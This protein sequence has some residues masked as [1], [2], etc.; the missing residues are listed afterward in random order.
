MTIDPQ[1]TPPTSHSAYGYVTACLIRRSTDD[2]DPDDLPTIRAAMNV[3][4]EFVP[5]R[6]Q[7]RTSDYPALLIEERVPFTVG[8]NGYIRDTMENSP[9]ALGVGDWT[10][11]FSG[12]PGVTLAPVEFSV[13]E[14]H[15]KAN[16]LNLYGLYPPTPPGG[17]NPVYLVVPPTVTVGHLLMLGASGIEG[18][19]PATLGGD[20]S[21]GPVVWDD[22]INKPTTFAPSAHRHDAS[23][24]D[25]LPAGSGGSSAWADITGKPSVYPPDTH[26]H[27]IGDVNGLPDALDGKQPLG[28]YAASSHTHDDLYAPL[29]TAPTVVAGTAY[30]LAAGDENVGIRTTSATAVTV[31]VPSGLPVGYTCPILVDGAGMVTVV[32]SGVTLVHAE[33]PVSRKT[34]ST[35]AVQIVASGRAFVV[36]D[37]A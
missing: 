35:L 13:T 21:G 34:G 11:T 24:I 28:A 37:F 6:G 20:G 36:G 14:D 23:E 27:T 2:S 17:T 15:T 26:P 7:H 3:T 25:N 30:T 33:P 22:V 8:P 9:I 10:A 31:T 4:G 32:G 18:I 1:V 29:R 16:P 19:D 5:K 12:P